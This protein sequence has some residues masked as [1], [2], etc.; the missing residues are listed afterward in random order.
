MLFRIN[1]LWW[2][3]LGVGSPIILPFLSVKNKRF[4]KNCGYALDLNKDR[5]DNAKPFKLPELD[6]LDLTILVE[7][8]AE[9]GYLGDAG[10]S[11]LFRTNLG[12]LLF[13][14]GFGPE[15]PALTHNAAKLGVNID[16]VDSLVISHLHP[17]HM[18]GMKASR[19]NQVTLPEQLGIPN[20]KP[21]FLP[22]KSEAKGFKSVQIDKPQLL[23]A[24]IATTGPLA[25]SL[26]FFGLTEEQALFAHV[27]GKGIVVFTGCGHPTI[28]LIVKMV[29]RLSNEHIYAIGGGLH[30]PI[31]GGRGNRAGIQFQTILGT[32]K[33]VWQK[34]TD[35]DL[36]K[37]KIGR[38]DIR[39]QKILL[40]GHDSCDHSL[41]RMS[42]ELVAETKVLKAGVTYHL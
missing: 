18:G 17:D 3:V 13:D 37:T 10:V 42:Q 29:N 26:F 40:S 33:P 28:E 23:T 11:Y 14:V 8:K 31:T 39:P 41:E 30:F 24:G 16:Q 9:K 2:P 5:L 6:F 7:E 12:T 27:K 1:L 22:A 4:K 25:R 38:N 32:G 34:I 36:N 35:N 15:R 19:L 20:G 21:C